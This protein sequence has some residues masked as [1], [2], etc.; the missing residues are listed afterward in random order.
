MILKPHVFTKAVTSAGTREQLTIS[1]K[2]ACLVLIQAPSTNTGITYLGDNQVSATNGIE[3]AASDSITLSA[4]DLGLG[5]AT[6]KLNELWLD[7]ATSA[8]KV[9]VFYLEPESQ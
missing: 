9:I 1:D 4:Q 3:L 7:V 8:D 2:Q 5:R 6:I